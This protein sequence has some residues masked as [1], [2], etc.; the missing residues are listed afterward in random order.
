MTHRTDKL[1]LSLPSLVLHIK[2]QGNEWLAQDKVS[3]NKGID[4]DVWL[5]KH[6]NW[7]GFKHDDFSHY[8]YARAYS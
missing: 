2:R 8:S 3:N 7:Q 4:G 5:G 1:Y 6:D